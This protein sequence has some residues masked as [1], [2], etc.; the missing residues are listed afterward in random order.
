MIDKGS[1]AKLIEN[2]KDK[3]EKILVSSILD[4]AM[5]FEKTDSV[6]ITSF[7]NLNELNV[8]KNALNHFKVTYY[9]L[10]IN[11][12]IEKR[13]I[14]FIPEFLSFNI[15]EIFREHVS[16]IKV[17]PKVQGKLIHKDYMGA[18]YSLGIKREF[19]GDIIANDKCAYF[20]CMKTAQDYFIQNLVSVG[21]QMVDTQVVDIF[22]EEIKKLAL[23]VIPKDYIIPSLRI[24]AILSEV[25]N[26]SRSEVKEKIVKGD[27]FI[28]D[29]AIYYPNTIVSEGDIISFKRCGKM[30]IGEEIRKTKSLNIVLRI[31]RYS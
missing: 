25:Y 28:N 13:N 18:I 23:N 21:K 26:L 31:Y 6:I 20:F 16:C 12:D 1:K 22:S 30:R 10:Y 29:K 15:Q 17:V 24:D 5:K 3:D 19:I 4:K 7:L 2:I 8:V 9:E 11:D 27:L 14:A